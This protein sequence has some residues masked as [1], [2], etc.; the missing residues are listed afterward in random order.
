[1]TVLHVY[2]QHF[3]GCRVFAVLRAERFP[4]LGRD[5]FAVID[6]GNVSFFPGKEELRLK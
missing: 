6:L 5:F 2:G 4:A 3:D 1:V